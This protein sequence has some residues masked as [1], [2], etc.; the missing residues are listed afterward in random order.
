[1]V[2]DAEQRLADVESTLLDAIARLPAL[3]REVQAIRGTLT[4]ALPS[5]ETT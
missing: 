4:A 5:G 1:M 3:A 2:R